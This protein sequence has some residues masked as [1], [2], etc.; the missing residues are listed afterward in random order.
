VRAKILIA[1]NA[2]AF[3][4]EI[5]R[6]TLYLTR[7]QQSGLSWR[8]PEGYSDQQL[9]EKLFGGSKPDPDSCRRP[10]PDFTYIQH[11]LTT[12]RHTCLQ[13]LWEEYRDA[14]PDHPYSYTSFWRHF[15]HWRSR[16][17]LVMRQQHRAGERLF[18]DWAGAKIPIH[19]RDTGEVTMASLFVAVLGASSYTYAEA[20][21]TQELEPWISAHMRTF[22]FLKGV[23]ELVVPD[24]ARTGVTK[25]CRYDPDLNP[26]YQ[27]MAMHYGVGVVPARVRKP[28]DKTCAS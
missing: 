11:E 15:D 14:H 1:E 28:R 20:A 19:D 26:T 4:L 24:N 10:L 25:A 17:D 2:I 21:I 18:V 7:F 12:N 23:P 5:S 6:E 22:E 16:Q 8:L 9:N 3:R 13:L 27:E